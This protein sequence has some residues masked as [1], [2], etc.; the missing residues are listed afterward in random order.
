MSEAQRR[1]RTADYLPAGDFP[2]TVRYHAEV[3]T[4]TLHGHEFSELVVV[5]GGAGLHVTGRDTWQL[6]AG[7]VFVLT[8]AREHRYDR[9]EK[10]SLYNVLYDE[11]RL[12][13]PETDLGNRGARTGARL[14]GRGALRPVGLLPR[15][16]VRA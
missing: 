12:A 14:H 2:V 9:T 3:D 7:D 10:L 5:T 8:G 16:A 13:L 6:S 15:P 4:G 1:L 11:S